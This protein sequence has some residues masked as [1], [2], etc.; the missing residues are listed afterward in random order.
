MAVVCFGLNNAKD[1]W[2]AAL[3][4]ASRHTLIK[5]DGQQCYP[6]HACHRQRG[7]CYQ[8]HAHDIKLVASGAGV[9]RVKLPGAFLWGIEMCMSVQCMSITGLNCSFFT[10]TCF[11]Q[12]R[13]F[14]WRSPLQVQ[15]ML[16]T[17]RTFA[18]SRV[19]CALELAS[20][21]HLLQ[22]HC[23]VVSMQPD[24]SCSGDRRLVAGRSSLCCSLCTSSC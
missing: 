5:V 17:A 3:Q 22:S 24:L 6:C 21:L 16:C 12:A 23:S 14:S 9:A 19:S 4:R 7:W 13:P 18:Q 20:R 15:R 10:Q 8:W 11:D 1:A 2:G